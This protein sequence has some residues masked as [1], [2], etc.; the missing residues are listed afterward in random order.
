MRI[1][2]QTGFDSG[3]SMEYVYA[4]VPSGVTTIGRKLDASYL[5]SPGWVAIRVR[6]LNVQ[7]L[8]AET[9][10]GI[11][12]KGRELHVLDIAAG[13]GRYVMDALLELRHRPQSVRLQEYVDANV[14]RGR[15]LLR[16]LGLADIAAFVH[17]DAFDGAALAA[18][19]P[20]PTLAIACGIYELFPDNAR[21]TDSLIGLSRAM[22]PDSCLLY[23]NQPYQPLLEFF[24]RV[25]PSHRRD[26]NCVVR[27]RTQ[28]EM[29][30]LVAHAGFAKISQIT[31]PQGIFSVSVARK[32]AHP[33]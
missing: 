2:L 18:L 28:A 20:R 33:E 32:I 8:I 19:R 12:Q 13:H 30:Q 24:V 23:T 7:R 25:V 9:A 6:R 1:G 3:S 21:V 27:R 11:Q 22:E 5:S 15:A 10:R 17:G 16:E 29:D 26:Q 4:N 14:Q 31:D